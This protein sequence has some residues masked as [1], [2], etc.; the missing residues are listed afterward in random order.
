ML[1]LY[2]NRPSDVSH[3]SLYMKEMTG[4]PKITVFLMT[5][6]VVYLTLKTKW[7]ID[8]AQF[9]HDVQY[10]IARRHINVQ[11]KHIF[12]PPVSQHQ[13]HYH[14]FHPWRL[15]TENIEKELIYHVSIPSVL[16]DHCSL[17]LSYHITDGR[18]YL[19]SWHNLN[20]FPL[21]CINPIEY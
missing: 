7:I 2:S 4:G 14:T 10:Q 9:F 6:S 19:G 21:H 12:L 1:Y 17:S 5:H 11:F 8:L 15:D 20:E 16:L 3:H 13:I 18:S